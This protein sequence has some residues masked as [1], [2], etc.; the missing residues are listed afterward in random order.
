[1]VNR[2]NS[3]RNAITKESIFTALMILMEKKDFHKIS[4]TEVTSKAGV[5]RMAFYRNYEILEDVITD[6]LTTF[7]AKYEEK[8]AVIGLNN[9]Y[10]VILMFFSSFKTEKTLM[11][12]LIKSNLTF[13]LLDKSNLFL[14]DICEK[15][16]CEKF[17][18][19]EKEKYTIKF[20]CGGFFNILVEWVLNDFKERETY[21]AELFCEYCK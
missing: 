3:Y 18:S 2:M 5:S 21:M 15:F 4:I 7:F 17:Y 6:Y 14:E 10:D 13:L 1:M 8:I 20:L 12:N 9:T 11:M 16:V 19:P